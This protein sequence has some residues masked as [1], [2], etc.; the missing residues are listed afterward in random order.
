MKFE[1]DTE[2]GKESVKVDLGERGD[3]A[4]IRIQDA[5]NGLVQIYAKDIPTLLL[6]I[7]A[8]QKFIEQEKSK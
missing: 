1:Y 2:F 5:V 3:V 7:E 4:L 8:A 6:G